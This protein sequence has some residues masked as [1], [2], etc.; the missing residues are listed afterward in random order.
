MAVLLSDSNTAVP[1]ARV[2]PGLH[3]CLSGTRR[4]SQASRQAG[5][6]AGA[7]EHRWAKSGRSGSGFQL[8]A[9]LSVGF[10]YGDP[11]GNVGNHDCLTVKTL[12][13]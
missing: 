11:S 7:L 1:V 5:A 3:K 8:S 13:L 12:D 9:S 6:P 10:A 2:T 4:E